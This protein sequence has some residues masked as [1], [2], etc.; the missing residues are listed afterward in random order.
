MEIIKK[1]NEK[2]Y[3]RLKENYNRNKMPFMSLLVDWIQ[4]R[5]KMFKF[6]DRSI[7]F[8]TTK[9]IRKHRLKEESFQG[10]TATTK[11]TPSFEQGFMFEFVFAIFGILHF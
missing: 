8:L 11:C 5:K 10:H 6:D 9:K 2:K 7:E 4:L 3:E 1:V